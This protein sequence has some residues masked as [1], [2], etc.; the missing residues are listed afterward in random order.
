MNSDKLGECNRERVMFLPNGSP[1]FMPL[2]F[3]PSGQDVL[4]EFV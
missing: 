4:L 3:V 1:D 2:G